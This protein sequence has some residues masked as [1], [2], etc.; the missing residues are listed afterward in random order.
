MLRLGSRSRET[1]KL[2]KFVLDVTHLLVIGFLCIF[3]LF[4]LDMIRTCAVV[5]VISFCWIVLSVLLGFS[6]LLLLK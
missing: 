1:S 3:V 5:C 2:L 6:N 4:F